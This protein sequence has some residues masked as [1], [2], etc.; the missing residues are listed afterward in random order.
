MQRFEEQFGDFD[1]FVANDRGGHTLFITNYTG[2]PQIL[3]PNGVDER[4]NSRS[5]SFIGRLF[6]EANLVAIAKAYQEATG[7]HK[8]HPTDAMLDKA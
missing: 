7:F 3:V 4:G 1:L 8:L 2:H 5:I 6:G